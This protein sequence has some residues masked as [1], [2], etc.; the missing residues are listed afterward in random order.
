MFIT[1]G[2]IIVLIGVILIGVRAFGKSAPERY[3]CWEFAWIG[4]FLILVVMVAL[5]ILSR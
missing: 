1:I 4:V 3:P 2:N 5:P